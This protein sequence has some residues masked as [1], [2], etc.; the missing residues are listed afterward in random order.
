MRPRV[1]EREER[2]IAGDDATLCR[3]R[4]PAHLRVRTES[5]IT[6]RETAREIALPPPPPLP[7]LSLSSPFSTLAFLLRESTNWFRLN[8]LRQISLAR[9][10][11]FSCR[12]GEEKEKKRQRT[13]REECLCRAIL[14]RNLRL[15]TYNETCAIVARVIIAIPRNEYIPLMKHVHARHRHN[16]LKYSIPMRDTLLSA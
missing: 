14:T 5:A 1:S 12:R 16:W 3:R 8:L 7:P 9:S 15:R 13:A 2:R 6:L 10:L 11:S 4:G